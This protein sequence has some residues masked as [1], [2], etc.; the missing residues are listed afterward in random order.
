M[1]PIH[2]KIVV[3]LQVQQMVQCHIQ[4]EQPISLLQHSGVT[5]DIRF[6]HLQHVHVKLTK[7]GVMRRQL[8]I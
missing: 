4:M 3:M 6:R 5:Q 2:I 1:S 8:A 7:H